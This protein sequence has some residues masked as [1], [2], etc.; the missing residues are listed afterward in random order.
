MKFKIQIIIVILCVITFKATKSQ[1]IQGILI[2]GMNLTQVDGDEVYGYKKTGLNAGVG[3]AL[4]FGKK[5]QWAFNIETTFS[6]KGAFEKYPLEAYD[7][8]KLPYYNLRL[9][10]AEIPAYITYKDKNGMTFGAGISISQLTGIK[11]IEHGKNKSWTMTNQPYDRFDF[12]ILVDVR[13]RIYSKLYFNFR[14]AY[15]IDKIRTR[16]FQT[17]TSTWKRDQFNNVLT[18]RLLFL[19]NERSAQ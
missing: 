11:E 2:G 9:N 12:D 5:K 15:S 18:F 4:P 1:N 7:S 10:Y 19:F 8:M 13:F 14:Y 16:D 6:Q 3:A 17:L